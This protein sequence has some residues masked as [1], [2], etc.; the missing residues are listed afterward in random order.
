MLVT[1]VIF[2]F[3]A[4]GFS[5]W[6]LFALAVNALPFF[7]GLTAGLAACQN[8]SG[9]IGAIV[10]GLVVGS[11][12]LVGAQSAF[13]TIQSRELRSAMTL[14][15]AAPAAVAGYHA[16]LG[17]AHVSAAPPAWQETFAFIGAVVVGGTAWARMAFPAPPNVRQ[18]VSAGSA[19]QPLASAGRDGKRS[20]RHLERGYRA[21]VRS[22][23]ATLKE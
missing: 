6:L 21:R 20:P 16:A 14:L 23:S 7:V 1:G 5:C 18:G 3:V 13:A 17:L 22:S 19:P 8:D 12:T 15:F 10:V 9:A 4:L 11:V 2:G